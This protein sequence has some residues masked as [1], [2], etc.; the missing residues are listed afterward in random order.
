[1]GSPATRAIHTIASLDLKHGGPSRSVVALCRA[2][3]GSGIDVDLISL[4]DGSRTSPNPISAGEARLHFASGRNS[5][6]GF[7]VGERAFRSRVAVAAEGPAGVPTLL[8]D[9]GLWLPTNHAVASYARSRRIPRLV[10][11]RGMMSRWALEQR[12][13]KKMLAWMAFQ[14][15]D[16]RG[17]D[18][19]HATSEQ[20]ALDARA[21]GMR[22]P[23]AIIPNGVDCPPGIPQRVRTG[24]ERH[25]LFLSRI[26]P[27][28]GLLSLVTAWSRL[29]PEG[30]SLIIAG[31]DDLGHRREVEKAV[32]REGLFGTVRFVGTISD[33]AKWDCLADADLLILPTFS[34]NFGM[35]VA[36][37]LA[38]ALPVITT[39]GAPWR[40]LEDHRCGWWI[41]IGVEPLVRAIREATDMTDCQRLELGTRGREYVLQALSWDSISRR[42]GRVYGWM[43]Q[44][45]DCPTDVVHV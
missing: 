24:P 37:A 14:S 40:A 12:R 31:P 17:A 29:R 18:A 3:T 35:V 15:R 42:M 28:K 41:D 25:A 16:L 8:H 32:L 11:P 39:K 30:W 38:S 10:S 43:L 6:G 26:H 2:L 36:E 22:Q 20:E 45:G 33:S 44:G 21:L 19:I 1:M 23:I 7:V 4:G 9:H 5:L 27:G 13:W 34:E